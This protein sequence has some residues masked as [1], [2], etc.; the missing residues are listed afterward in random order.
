MVKRAIDEF[1]GALAFAPG[2]ATCQ[3]ALSQLRVLLN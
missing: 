1:E 3:S 2:D